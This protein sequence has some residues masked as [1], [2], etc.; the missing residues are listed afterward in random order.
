MPLEIR[1]LHIR[2]SVGDA[3]SGT[4]PSEGPGQGPDS[5][6]FV[7]IGIFLSDEAPGRATVTGPDFGGWE[8]P[9][10]AAEPETTFLF[11][12]DWI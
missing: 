12:D 5:F 4:G 3:A 9:G 6:D 11:A 7:E 10:L 1:E 2:V 8:P